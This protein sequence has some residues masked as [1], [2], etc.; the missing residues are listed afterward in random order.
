MAL[1]PALRRMYVV[2]RD[3]PTYWPVVE[4]LGFRPFADS[5]AALDGVEYT[6]VVLDFG[7][8]SVD[9]WLAELVAGELGVG[10]EPSSTRRRASSRCRARASR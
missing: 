9:G 4:Q 5:V 6:T 2:V 8:G 3:V 10:D 7:P 1:R